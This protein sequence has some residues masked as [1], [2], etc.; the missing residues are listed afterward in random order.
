MI[1][2]KNCPFH[3]VDG[4]ANERCRVPLCQVPVNGPH[5]CIKMPIT[6]CFYDQY[7]V[8]RLY[9]NDPLARQ[10]APNLLEK[11]IRGRDRALLLALFHAADQPTRSIFWNW[12]EENEPRSLWLLNP[13]FCAAGLLPLAAFSTV[14]SRKSEYLSALVANPYSGSSYQAVCH[15][16]ASI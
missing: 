7:V 3:P 10:L 6:R 11:A 4:F 15:S 5:L 14:G 2:C 13:I 12:L 1:C 9:Q 16:L 8:Y